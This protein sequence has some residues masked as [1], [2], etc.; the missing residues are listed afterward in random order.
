MLWLY[1]C[2]FW[3]V[4]YSF[5]L[6]CKEGDIMLNGFS[7]DRMALVSQNGAK[8]LS[9]INAQSTHPLTFRTHWRHAQFSMLHSI[10]R[11]EQWSM[12]DY[13]ITTQ[14]RGEGSFW[15][16]RHTQLHC[17]QTQNTQECVIREHTYTDTK[18]E[19]TSGS[20]K[21]THAVWGVYTD[22]AR[23]EF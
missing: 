16:F 3:T 11:W 23:A 6:P 13:I 17:F 1:S 9:C 15:Y 21:T 19:W 4:L 10:F 20:H 12:C 18:I 7:D 2:Y 5:A 14:N 8:Y 22:H